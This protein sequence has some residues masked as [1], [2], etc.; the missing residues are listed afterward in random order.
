MGTADVINNRNVGPADRY[1]QPKMRTRGGLARKD[2]YARVACAALRWQEVLLNCSMKGAC[3]SRN[4][5][6]KCS[7]LIL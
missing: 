7:F 6:I 1:Q 2:R 5:I 4:C 3:F